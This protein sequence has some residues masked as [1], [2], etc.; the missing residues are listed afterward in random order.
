MAN[1]K[2]NDRAESETANHA[3]VTR[4][5]RTGEVSDRP[6][7][8]PTVGRSNNGILVFLLGVV[9][10]LLLVVLVGGGLYIFTQQRSTQS[11][12]N[13]I[14]S[15]NEP[16][17]IAAPP[18]TQAETSTTAANPPTA[19]TAIDPSLPAPQTLSLQVNHANGTTARLTGITFSD[20]HITADLSVTN[21]HR[22]GIRLNNS[23]DMVIAD[24]LG[25]QYNLVEPPNNEDI[26]IDPNTTLK[27]KFVFNG[28]IAPGAT[29]LTLTT[30]NR[31]GGNENF[32][33][34]PKMTFNIPL[35]GEGK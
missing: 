6:H 19:T 4:G 34:N 21:G 33:N 22:N 35:Q 11:A 27:G 3:N 32:S 20:D 5:N 1:F 23:H 8:E 26:R 10:T 13:L 9:S 17:S 31:F 24:N 28:R 15:N 12:T 25:N 18:P 14:P 30:N 7:A 2:S 29:T 16:Q